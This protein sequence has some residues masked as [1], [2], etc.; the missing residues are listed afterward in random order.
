MKRIIELSKCSFNR[1]LDIGRSEREVKPG[2]AVG[3]KCIFFLMN[4]GHNASTWKRLIRCG[5]VVF[6]LESRC[7]LAYHLFLCLSH[8]L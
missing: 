1:E 2:R 6:N 5:N 8:P 7:K 3:L 4:K